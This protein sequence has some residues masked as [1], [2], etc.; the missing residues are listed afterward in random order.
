MAIV[1][2]LLSLE[3][4]DVEFSIYSDVKGAVVDAAIDIERYINVNK[5]L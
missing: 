5:R 4:I 2:F 1:K 3:F